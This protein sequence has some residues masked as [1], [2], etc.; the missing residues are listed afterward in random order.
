MAWEPCRFRLN[1]CSHAKRRLSSR[2]LKMASDVLCDKSYVIPNA[3]KIE[4]LWFVTTLCTVPY[5]TYFLR[6]THS[7]AECFVSNNM[8]KNLSWTKRN[9]LHISVLETL[10]ET[11]YRQRFFYQNG[12]PGRSILLSPLL[13]AL[14][15]VSRMSIVR[16]QYHIAEVIV[17]L[18]ESQFF[19]GIRVGEYSRDQRLQ[20]WSV[21]HCVCRQRPQA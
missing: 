17:S 1:C 9:S 11:P 19:R 2:N 5:F 18:L 15:I 4:S 8:A 21:I 7:S 20:N 6:Y 12:V 14:P 10:T 13:L 3:I 16:G